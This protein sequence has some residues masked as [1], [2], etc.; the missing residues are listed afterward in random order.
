V[1]RDRF[2]GVLLIWSLAL[3]AGQVWSHDLVFPLVPG[4]AR[5]S[6]AEPLWRALAAVPDLGWLAALV[7]VA[8]LAGVRRPRRALSAVLAALVV[9]LAFHAAWRAEDPSPHSMHARDRAVDTAHAHLSAL[10]VEVSA[11]GAPT[12]VALGDTIARPSPLSRSA[13]IAP[14]PGRAPP[15]RSS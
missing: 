10:P 5:T 14:A 15:F 7:V 13:S 3:L 2:S 8:L 9:A 6:G 1:R 4:A 12:L 11:P